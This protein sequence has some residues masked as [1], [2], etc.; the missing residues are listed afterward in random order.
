MNGLPCALQSLVTALVRKPPAVIV[1][2]SASARVVKASTSMIP[3]VFAGGG[4]PIKTGLVT[5][6]NRPGGNVT[7]VHFI[8]GVPRNATMP[9]WNTQPW[10]RD[11]SKPGVSTGRS[12]FALKQPYCFLTLRFDLTS[13]SK[14]SCVRSEYAIANNATASS[15]TSLLPI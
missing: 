6:L 8:V 13:C 2:N 4:D 14:S 11:N 15:R 7:G 1:A 3:L 5:S 10:R 9:C 12:R